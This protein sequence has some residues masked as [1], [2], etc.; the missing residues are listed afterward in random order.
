[1]RLQHGK[2]DEHIAMIGIVGHHEAEA[3]R[4]VEPFDHARYRH[5]GGLIA[6]G[7]GMH[8]RVIIVRRVLHFGTH[9]VHT[10]IALLSCVLAKCEKLSHAHVSKRNAVSLPGTRRTIRRASSGECPARTIAPTCFS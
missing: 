4:H 7:T 10:P 3:A 1:M 9:I 8:G 6:I 2:M 5:P